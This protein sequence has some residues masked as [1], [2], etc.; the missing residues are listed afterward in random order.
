MAKRSLIWIILI[1]G[2]GLRL[3]NINQSFWLDE[4]SQAQL[5]AFTIN[6]I[7]NGRDT[8]FQPPLFYILAHFWMLLGKSEVW[9]RLLPISFG[10]ASVAAIY[11]LSQQIFKSDKVSLIAAFLL[12]INPYH[13]YYSQEFR[14][15]SLVFLLAIISVILLI[16]QSKYWFVVTAMLFYTHYSTVLFILFQL[17]YSVFV[18]K[19]SKWFI[20]Q[21]ILS[22]VLYIPWIPHLR[23]QLASGS[24]IDTYLPGWRQVLSLPAI[25]SFPEII[26]KFVAGRIN[27]F[28]K[29]IYYVYIAFVLSVTVFSLVIAKAKRSLL[30]SWVFVPIL[31]SI[32]IS[33]LVPQTQPFR[34][35]FVLPALI[36][37]FAQGCI[38]YPRLMITLLVYISIVG[39]VLYFTRPR[40]QR[41]QWRQALSFVSTKPGIVAVKFGDAFAPFAWYTPNLPVTGLVKKYPAEKS[42]VNQ[43][44]SLLNLK[45]VYLFDYLT[46]LTDPDN[47]VNESLKEHGFVNDATYDYEGVGFI[48]HYVIP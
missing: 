30:W 9:L 26:F 33:P 16:K 39:N 35:I 24:N 20:S 17:I 45:D 8:D 43:N 42:D 15:Y 37:V 21:L 1:L 18:L 19:K 4:A 22:A 28:P 3:V 10:V 36:L 5:S 7:W 46:G 44:I 41:E 32:I 47:V 13:I 38:K 25:K 27:I 40:L 2:L 6:Q 11:S 12:A 23:S 34:L 29:Y 31:V 14:M 48:F